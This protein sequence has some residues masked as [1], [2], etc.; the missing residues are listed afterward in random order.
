MG[1]VIK[2]RRRRRVRPYHYSAY[3]PRLGRIGR[4]RPFVLL[5]LLV[6]LWAATDQGLIEPIGPLATEPERV[7]EQ[8]TR[9]GRGRAHGCVIDGD[10]F[11][12]GQR[13]IRIIGI[14]AP[15]THPPRCPEEAA[16]GEAAT[17]RLQTLLNE[18]PFE[19]IGNRADAL[20]IY[21][22]DLRALYRGDSSIAAQLRDEGLVR[23]Y[24][25]F[26]SGWC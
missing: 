26:K 6:F 8:F 22:R 20:D 14:D 17:A 10:T 13:T 9:C 25:G 7:D 4:A 2:F 1:R 12:L 24:A 11:K 3:R 21:G 16:K 19:M 15:E 23:R 5:G 18:G